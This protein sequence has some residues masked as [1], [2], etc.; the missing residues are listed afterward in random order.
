MDKATAIITEA[1]RYDATAF[2]MELHR[3]RIESE[4]DAES[5]SNLAARRSARARAHTLAQM[6]RMTTARE[7]AGNMGTMV[8][9]LGIAG[10]IIGLNSIEQ[11]DAVRDW[12]ESLSQG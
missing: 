4:R 6:A 5:S 8:L 2:A 11:A 9:A 1:I 10:K 7:L 3:Q 12:E